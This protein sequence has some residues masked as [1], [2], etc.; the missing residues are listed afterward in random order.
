MGSKGLGKG[1]GALFAEYE[2][3]SVKSDSV[4]EEKS[5]VRVET[6]IET[7][8]KIVE[9]PSEI[10]ISLIDRN[11]EQ[12]RKTFNEK[13][14]NELADSIK[15]HGIIQPL[16]L[17]QKGERYMIIAG[18]R[19]FRAAKLAG[20]TSVPA[21]IKNFT[22]REIREISIIENL[23]REDLNPIESAMA[24]KELMDRYNLKQETIADRIGKSRP[25]VANT[26]RLL[27]LDSRVVEMIRFGKLSASHARTL[28]VIEDKN[29]QYE[30]AKLASDSKISVH[31]MEK[32]VK[33]Y[34]KKPSKQNETKEQSAELKAFI[35][36]MQKTFST[37]VSILGNDKKGRIFIDYYNSDD[38]QRIYNVI[39]KLK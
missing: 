24:I 23:Q 28:V 16:V 2:D 36:N 15:I 11:E 5:N 3:Y 19:R 6:K 35:I 12:P 27:T 20:L 26:L 10:K 33:K 9:R 1:L 34:L 30:L 18:E 29:A 17:Q 38:L 13:A 21:I 39:E 8:E 14:L 31:E 7:I 22:D 25:A 37:K 4:K 32:T